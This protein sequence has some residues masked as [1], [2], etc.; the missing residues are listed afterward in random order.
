MRFLPLEKL[1]NLHDGYRRRFK[2]DHWDVLLLQQGTE[3]HV[4][5][6]RCPHQEQ[7]LE[8]A[9]IEGGTIYCPRHGFG[10][11]LHTGK[12]TDG[13]CPALRIWQPTYEGNSVGILVD[14]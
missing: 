1:I 4:I 5:D 6:T 12:H 3:V 7:S 8:V 11:S 9:D 14:N 10:F 13:F 2:I